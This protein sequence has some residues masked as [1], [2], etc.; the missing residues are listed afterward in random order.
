MNQGGKFN[1]VIN[2]NM[3]AGH[4][5]VAYPA[6]WGVSGVMTF[7]VNQRGRVYEKNLGPKS[8]EIASKLKEYNPDLTWKLADQ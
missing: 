2:G 3:V 4:A 1:Y 7:I 8:A 5:L 6:K